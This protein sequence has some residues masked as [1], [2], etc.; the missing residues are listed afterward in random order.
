M[1]D[2]EFM[3]K[4]FEIRMEIDQSDSFDALHAI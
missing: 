4:V 1:E 3:E 2:M